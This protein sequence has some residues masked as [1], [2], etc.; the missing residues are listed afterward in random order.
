MLV[1]DV[2]RIKEQLTAVVE[3]LEIL[4]VLPT[5]VAEVKT[6]LMKLEEDNQLCYAVL[7]EQ[8]WLLR[9]QQLRIKKLASNVRVEA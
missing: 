6:V 9:N 4:R 5:D 8:G 7:K 3:L 1:K 2:A